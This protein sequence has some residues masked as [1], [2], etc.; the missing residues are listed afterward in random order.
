MADKELAYGIYEKVIS[1]LLA[2]RLQSM[3]EHLQQRNKIDEAESAHVLTSYLQAII[4]HALQLVKEKTKDSSVAEQIA[5]VNQLI[6]VMAKQAGDEDLLSTCVDPRGEE[7]LALIKGK[8][9]VL[10]L[11]RKPSLPRPETSL[12]QTSLF[13]G[14]PNEPSMFNEL[15]KE[16]LSCN[17]MDMLVSFIKWS[18]LRLLYDELVEFTK[19]GGRLR[20]IATSYMG[21]TDVK[22]I[23]ELQKLPNTEI[24]MS[25]DTKRTR[26]HAKAYIF[27]RDTGYHTA[28]IG[29]SNLS[30]AAISS[31][32]EWN[33][34]ITAS[35]EPA[36]FAKIRATFESYWN[37][38]EFESYTAEKE[39]QLT[40]AISQEHHHGKGDSTGYYFTIT[41][42]AYQREILDAIAAE[43]KYHDNSRNLIVAATGTGKTV[44]AAFDYQ[45]YCKAHPKENNRLL[46]VAHREEILKQSLDCFRGVLQNANFGDLFVGSY[47]PEQLDHLFMSIQTFQS[48]DWTKRTS[49]DFYD[50]IVVDEFHHAAAPSYLALLEYYQPKVLLG[51]TATPERMDGKDVTEWFGGRITAELRLPEAIERGM[52]CPFHYFG[53]TDT[54]DLSELHWVRGGY[55]KSALENVYVMQR[56]VADRRVANIVHSLHRYVTDPEHIH[57]LGFCVSVEHAK[58]MATAFCERGIPSLALSGTS[59]D[60]D[61]DSARSKLVAG[62][63]RF[64]FVVDLYNEGVDIPEVDT[65]LFLRPTES[66]TVFLQQLGRGLRL[67]DDKEC[68]TVL[69]YIGQAHQKYRFEEKYAALLTNTRQS[70]EH[71]IKN[72]FTALPHGS[73]IQLE[74]IAKD[75]VLGNIRAALHGK[76]GLIKKMRDF[77]E[78]SSQPLTL[79][80]FV[81]YHHMTLRQFYREAAGFSF[82][83]LAADAG[84]RS[85][86][87]RTEDEETVGS[88]LIRLAAI[89][90]QRWLNFLKV[91]LARPEALQENRLDSVKERWLRMLHFT[92]WPA[93]LRKTELQS[94]FRGLQRLCRMP[95]LLQEIREI[96]DYQLA[97]I[98]FV[99]RPL[100]IG[101]PCPLDVHCHYTRD[102]LLVAL[103]YE[104]T[105]SVR[106]GVL[107]IPDKKLD[108]FMVTLNKTQK[109]YSPT[110]MYNDYS[111]SESLFHWQSQSTTSATSPTAQRYIHH[112]ERGNKVLLFVRE[113]K[114]DT[115]NKSMPYMCLGLIKYV[116]HEG[117]KPMD[118]VW[119]LDVPIP[120]KF[121]RVTNKLVVE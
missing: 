47:H 54:V 95:V 7:L 65:I 72:G 90:S 35:D 21:A 9:T 50:Y 51:L 120:A 36:T 59:P 98:D 118:M 41:P 82:N 6:H 31:G 81:N 79:A 91:V 11:Q 71:Q 107:Y 109:A 66:L 48:K 1:E 33:V 77:T 15:K 108:I 53:V 42:F 40:Q 61:R 4:E 24:K 30:H 87:P 52:L 99:D 83:R 2:K 75:Y 19:Q 32:L 34:K 68:L 10:T 121:L 62:D 45:R 113:D 39:A 25:Y 96:V 3:D 43:R 105:D 27:Y 29:S 67:T 8:D 37:T 55:E 85:D 63:I 12:I 101:F 76:T 114:T 18:G 14:A 94:S 97:H 119:H 16:I 70:V 13:T 111:M 64:I 28:Y 86:F 73:Y 57:G 17:R 22:A 88:A 112:R 92:L 46:F 117:S 100:D 60:E 5:L 74:R 26:L 44:I 89:D 23:V 38:S 78:D 106:Q 49:K 84:Q 20:L 116:S 104:K 69:D 58:Y 110:T 56:A 115:A 102:Q 93:N 103:G 80:N